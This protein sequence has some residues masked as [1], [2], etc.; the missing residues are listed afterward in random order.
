MDRLNLLRKR[1]QRMSLKIQ[2][3]WRLVRARRRVTQ[4]KKDHIHARI[5]T[6]KLC[7]LVRRHR[8][9]IK[10]IWQQ[11]R[12]AFAI[13]IQ[14]LMRRGL[15]NMRITRLLSAQRADVEMKM[16]IHTR[17]NQLLAATQLQIIRD[18]MTATIGE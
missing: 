3:L 5:L 1:K 7:R 17:L 13:K 2:T 6:R 16:F 12:A 8:F 15:A 4:L 18:T 11:Q 9:H 10:Y 14:A